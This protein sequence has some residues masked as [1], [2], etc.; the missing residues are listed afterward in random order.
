[1]DAF[2]KFVKRPVVRR[3]IILAVIGFV[4]YLMRSMITLF[5]LTFIFI[6]LVNEAQKFIYRYINKIIPIKRSI[7]I[8]FIYI[9]IIAVIALL[10]WAYIPQ[11]VT[12]TSEAAKLFSSYVTNLLNNK[13][14]GNEIADTILAQ[15][16]KLDLESYLKNSGKYLVSFIGNIWTL[17]FNFIMALILSLFFLLQKSRIYSF[18]RNFKTSK[19]GWLYDDISYF[20]T[21]F[22]NS[23]GKVIQTQILISAINCLFSVLILSVMKFPS[24]L[25]LGVMIFIL[26]LIP[27]AG[28]FISLIPLSIFAYTIGGFKYIIY[29]IVLIAILH[30]IESYVLNPKLM[31]DKT[32]LPIFFTFLILII[33]NHFF[34]I[35]GLL[36][37]IPVFVFILDILEVDISDVK[38]PLSATAKLIAKK[39]LEKK[40]DK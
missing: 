39:R 5:L 19:V 30:S 2:L 25:G 24:V 31:S 22:T 20:G 8:A 38:H 21:V 27:V 17:G 18:M 12:Q 29:I 3:L 33:S 40:S 23:F 28:V 14:T 26:G 15:L 36:V 10:L 34:G 11:I 9:L 4:L 1:M 6:Y 16:R 35:W 37:G 13:S 7:I 32:N